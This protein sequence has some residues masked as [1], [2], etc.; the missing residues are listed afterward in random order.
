MVDL[1]VGTGPNG[2]QEAARQR[3]YATAFVFHSAEVGKEHQ[4]TTAT[5]P[6]CGHSSCRGIPDENKEDGMAQ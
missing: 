3:L 6:V 2:Q 1:G 5:E 4:P